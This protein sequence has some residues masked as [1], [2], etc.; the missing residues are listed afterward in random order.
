VSGREG[1]GWLRGALVHGLLLLATLVTIFPVLWV[2]K[3]AFAPAQDLEVSANPL[4]TSFSLENV[5]AVVATRS[6]DGSWLFGRQLL[7]SLVVSAA[8]ALLGTAVATTA[9]YALSRWAF[10]G[11]GRLGALMLLTQSFPGVVMAV[12]LYLLLDALGLL[13]RQAGLVLV[14]ATTA[15]PFST[16]NL[17]GWFDTLPRELEEAA[18]MDGASRWTTF[19]YVLLPL[20]RPALAVTTLFSFLAAW[21]EFILAATLLGDERAWTLPVVLHGYVGEHGA[22][23]GRFS[24]GAVLVSLPV[25]ALFFF[26]QKQLVEGLAAGSVKG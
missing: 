22:D 5:Q 1:V 9:G 18:M 21:N 24:A 17:K 26:L 10:P 19:W 13:D 4:P 23:W 14:Y 15:V 12:P 25:V 8:T 2:L 6:A 20:S 11:R 3:L 7:N 16:W